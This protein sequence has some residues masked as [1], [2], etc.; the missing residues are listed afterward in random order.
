[1]IYELVKGFTPKLDLD[2]TAKSMLVIGTAKIIWIFTGI[3]I[4]VVETH[5]G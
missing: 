3:V 2:R 1:M 5:H 4:K